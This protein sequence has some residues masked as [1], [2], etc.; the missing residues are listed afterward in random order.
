MSLPASLLPRTSTSTGRAL[1]G[2]GTAALAL[3]IP[4]ILYARS[5]KT[6]TA[7]AQTM[8]ERTKKSKYITEL[9]EVGTKGGEEKDEVKEYDIVIIGGGMWLSLFPR[10][11]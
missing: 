11:R 9:S 1:L 8:K 5:R 4:L 7:G 6:K 2:A 10:V 3:G